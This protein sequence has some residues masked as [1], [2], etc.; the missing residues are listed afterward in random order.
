MSTIYE[1]V[2]EICLGLPDTEETESHGFPTFKVAGKS[3]ATYSVNHHGDEKVALLLNMDR[4]SQQMLVDSAPDYFFV[5]PYSGTKGWVGIELNK[6]LSWNRVSE[7]SC[8]AYRRVAPASMATKVKPVVVNPP[9][10]E[11]RAED[12][13]PLRSKHCAEIVDRIGSFC[14]ALPE[15]SEASQ[16]GNP[17]FKAGK[18]S[19]GVISYHDNEMR[20]QVWVGVDLQSSLTSMD[21]RYS[22]PAYIG[23]NGWINFSLGRKP[24]AGDQ[25]WDEI[26]DLLL[27]S[28]KHFALKRMLNKLAE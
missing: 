12:I 5:P 27:N 9:T 24:L 16:F 26:D 3:F 11:M 7:L 15:V 21:K 4:A 2:Q 8:D 23:H 25:K 17:S 28:Y 22:I 18:K 20:L 13:N 10:V 1:V 14:L 19:F 6:D